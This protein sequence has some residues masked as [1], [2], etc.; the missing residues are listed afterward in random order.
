MPMPDVSATLSRAQAVFAVSRI[1]LVN[2][3]ARVPDGS[4]C[5]DL[6]LLDEA[7]L[8]VILGTGVILTAFGSSRCTRGL[9]R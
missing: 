1:D 2:H 9:A 5:L 7:I 8:S 3:L 6:V 4:G